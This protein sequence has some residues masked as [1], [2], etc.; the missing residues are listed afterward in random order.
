MGGDDVITSAIQ[1]GVSRLDRLSSARRRRCSRLGLCGGEVVCPAGS[2]GCVEKKGA[3]AA[4]GNSSN[5][6]TN[7]Q[8]LMMPIGFA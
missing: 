5:Y 3:A 8:M 6:K 2:V 1:A 4:E 7:Y